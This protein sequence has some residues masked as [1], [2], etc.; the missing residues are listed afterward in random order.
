M[1]IIN[2]LS[3]TSSNTQAA[4]TITLMNI[5]EKEFIYAG[6]IAHYAAVCS[7]LTQ[8]RPDVGGHDWPA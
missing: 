3:T 2:E 5:T 7:A 6:E 4:H 1:E 8:R